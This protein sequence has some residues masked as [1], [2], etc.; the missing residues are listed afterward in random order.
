MT[1]ANII[2]YIGHD[3]RWYINQYAEWYN[4]FPNATP[5]NFSSFNLSGVAYNW[6]Y[7][8]L[9]LKILEIPLIVLHVQNIYVVVGVLTI[10]LLSLTFTT[11]Y[12][13]ARELNAKHAFQIALAVLILMQV[14]LNINYLN[15]LP[16]IL[17]HTFMYLGIYA[18]LS[19][20]YFIFTLSTIGLIGTSFTTSIIAAMIYGFV[21]LI[22][23]ATIEEW[24]Q[25]LFFGLIGIMASMPLLLPI[26]SHIHDVSQPTQLLAINQPWFSITA[27]SFANGTLAPNVIR[28]LLP[29]LVL[30]FAWLTYTKYESKLIPIALSLMALLSLSPYLSSLATSFIQPGTWG[31]MYSFVYVSALFIFAKVNLDKRSGYLTGLATILLLLTA[32]NIPAAPLSNMKASPFIQAVRNKDWHKATIYSNTSN[33]IYTKA[34]TPKMKISPEEYALSSPDYMPVKATDK[35]NTI[36]FERPEV[37][38]KKYGFKKQT[39]NHGT[40][41]K[42]TVDPK[43][44]TTPLAVWHY[45]FVNYKVTS[46]HG[47][48][49]I[50]DR[51]MFMYKGSKKTVI[52][53]TLT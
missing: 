32:V 53:I 15:S 42:I 14:P 35:D 23:K 25:T 10:I 40:A 22:R 28:L 37:Q 8:N 52:T 21:L 48:V 18:L 34:G 43:Q 4:T 16:Q 3:A 33:V 46:T 50:S 51:D 49:F 11:I 41:L 2:T 39:V 26:L 13:A 12:L 29:V 6:F 47:K 38:Y 5:V 44:N 9:F 31:R 17:A 24:L 27:E 45:D 7:P 20:R 30:T 19:K 1:N 36:N